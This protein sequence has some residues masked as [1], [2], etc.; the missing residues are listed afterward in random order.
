MGSYGPAVT[1]RDQWISVGIT[2]GGTLILTLVWM[3]LRA[4]FGENPYIDSFSPMPF[5]I[6]VLF[7]MPFTSLKGR[8]RA[9]QA[10]FIGGLLLLLT[11]GSW[12]VGFVSARS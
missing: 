8:S 5:L 11:A 9:S 6:P 12:L 4:V 10:V 2:L 1:R 3:R 7:S